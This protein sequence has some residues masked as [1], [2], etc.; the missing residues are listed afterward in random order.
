M[1]YSSA[2]KV[3]PGRLKL[4]LKKFVTPFYGMKKEKELPQQHPVIGSEDLIS[5]YDLSSAFQ[6][7]CG[8]RK[9]KEDLSAFLTNVAATSNLK[10]QQDS[11]CSLKHLVEKPPITGKDV[12]PL[13]SSA[14]SG[15]KFAPGPVPE[16]YQFFDT[17]PSDSTL[18]NG[19][20]E[21]LP[22]QTDAEGDEH[23]RKRIKRSLDDYE[24]PP[25]KK[26]KKHRSGEEKEKKQKKKKKDKKRKKNDEEAS[27]S[28]R[29]KAQDAYY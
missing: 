2:A 6:R 27:S 15:F 19:V 8:P 18:L 4:S 17:I 11:S 28:K 3:S 16:Q 14:M 26:S 25:E 22:G 1:E 23:G 29:V 5:Y 12:L 24:E 21:R 20:K 10:K 7:F 9:P 13:S